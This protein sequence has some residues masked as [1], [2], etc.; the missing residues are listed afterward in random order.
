MVE[1]K[2]V[3]MIA[4]LLLLFVGLALGLYTIAPTLAQS[5]ALDSDDLSL[6][7]EVIKTGKL[8][9]KEGITVKKAIS[10]AGGTTAEAASRRAIIFRI[11][12]ATGKRYELKVDLDA[13]M[14]GRKQDVELEP[15]DIIIIPSKSLKKRFIDMLPIPIKLPLEKAG[16]RKG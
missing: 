15:G 2:E 9:F 16:A 6:A 12:P 10:L 14:D 1:P 11:E 3:S 13:V 5:R 8:S 7:G 4:K